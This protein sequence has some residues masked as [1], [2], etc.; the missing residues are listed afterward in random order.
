[1]VLMIIDYWVLSI[2]YIN[3]QEIQSL[4]DKQQKGQ[5]VQNIGSAN[6]G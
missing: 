2:D 4:L 5:N 6:L 3:Y 1:M